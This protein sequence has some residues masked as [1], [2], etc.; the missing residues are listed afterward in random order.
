MEHYPVCF[1]EEYCKL[2]VYFIVAGIT[3]QSQ[4]TKYSNGKIFMPQMF[5]L[6]NICIYSMHSTKTNTR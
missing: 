1:M 3:V 5:S 2:F 4:V 6:F